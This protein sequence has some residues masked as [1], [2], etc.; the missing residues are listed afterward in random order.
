MVP[1]DWLDNSILD[2]DIIMGNSVYW[3]DE[4]DNEIWDDTNLSSSH[5]LY[6]HF[7]LSLQEPQLYAFDENLTTK[8]VKLN[9]FSVEGVEFV[10]D[11]TIN[12]VVKVSVINS[13]GNND[14]TNVPAITINSATL[15]YIAGENPQFTAT[16]AQSSQYNVE[17]ETNESDEILE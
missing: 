17:Y 16:S 12:V 5:F 1:V 10:D 15:E 4:N 7:E 3:L 14:I 11:A 13:S 6:G 9:G 8:S 2:D